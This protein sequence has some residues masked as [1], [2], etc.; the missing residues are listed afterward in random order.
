MPGTVQGQAG[1]SRDKAGT[2]RQGQTGTTRDKQGQKGSPCL[3]LLV[4]VCA[5]LVPALS[6]LVP[7]FP[8]TKIL[9]FNFFFNSLGSF[10]FQIDILII[11]VVSILNRPDEAGSVQQTMPILTHLLAD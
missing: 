1:T 9:L 5:C 7:A 6:L 2:D 8:C 4:R 11:L 3:S 10:S